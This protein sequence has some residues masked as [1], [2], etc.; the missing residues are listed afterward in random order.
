VGTTLF[1]RQTNGFEAV[2]PDVR[3]QSVLRRVGRCCRRVKS[4]D[5]A[6]AGLRWRGRRRRCR[7][8]RS[9]PCRGSAPGRPVAARRWRSAQR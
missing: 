2:E 5:T 6:G 3:S 4:R 7:R 8:R 9:R 1:L